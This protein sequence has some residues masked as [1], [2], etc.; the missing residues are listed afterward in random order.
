MV[1]LLFRSTTVY[2]KEVHNSGPLQQRKHETHNHIKNLE[3]YSL[4]LS[5][6]ATDGH[7]IKS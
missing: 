1:K 3:I 6:N 5:I 4:E 7:L 2:N